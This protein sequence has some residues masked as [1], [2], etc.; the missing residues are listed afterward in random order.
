VTF[1][2]VSGWKVSQGHGVAYILESGGSH[3]ILNVDP[4][5]SSSADLAQ[6]EPWLHTLTFARG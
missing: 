5:G 3:A 1:G 4:R 2:A 6:V